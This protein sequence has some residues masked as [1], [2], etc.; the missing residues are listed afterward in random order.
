[1]IAQSGIIVP[2]VLGVIIALALY[3]RFSSAGTAPLHF[4][5]F[6]GVAMAVTAFPVLAR[7]L[8]DRHIHQTPIGII[9]LGAAALGDLTIWLLL[10]INNCWV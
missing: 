3:P 1:M 4:A 10:A 7:I 6:L 8:T 2:F 9:A 5:L